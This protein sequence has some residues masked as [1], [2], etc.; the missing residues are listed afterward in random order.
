MTKVAVIGAGAWGTA[1]ACALERAKNDVLIWAMEEEVVESINKKNENKIFLSGIKL[2]KKIKATGE[3]KDVKKSDV[4]YIVS[5]AQF[6]RN[7]CEK[8]VE[9]KIKKSIPIVICSKGVEKGS[10][11]MMSEVIAETMP[12]TPVVLSGPTFAHEVANGLP[13]SVTIACQDRRV[14]NKVSKITESDSFKVFKSNDIVGAQIGGSVKNVLA[15]AC[16][17]AEG[18]HLGENA[19]AA[20]ITRGLKEMKRLCVK[21]GGKPK[22]LME[23]CGVGDVILTCSS[24]QSRNYSLGF[25]LGKGK[26]LEEIMSKRRTVAE[27][28]ASSESVV[29]L[30][31]ELG[32]DVP[33]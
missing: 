17:M 31:K 26:T 18:K 20:L 21:K 11:K 4:I 10:L 24:Q 23:L 13:A 30:A 12:N 6:L 33:I 29:A 19:K 8:L 28:V 16:G 32:V 27:G 2:S 25:A 9:L 15:I 7:T 1:M 14:R 5:P 22:T 3:L